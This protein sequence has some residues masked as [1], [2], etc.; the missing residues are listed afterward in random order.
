MISQ[1]V[2]PSQVP[3]TILDYGVTALVLIVLGAVLW[4]VF[5]TQ[6]QI[7]ADHAEAMAKL[8]DSMR[9]IKEE[10]MTAVTETR[11]IHDET[12]RD[13][14]LVEA[15]HAKRQAE[16]EEISRRLAVLEDRLPAI[17]VAQRRAA[18]SQT[19]KPKT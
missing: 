12:L 14:E 11:H 8:A 2:L 19:P 6:R 17:S 16:H 3:Y 15:R 13:A 10:L 9:L 1:Q 7:L 5:R 4:Y 18:R